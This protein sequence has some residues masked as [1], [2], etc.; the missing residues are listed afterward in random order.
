MP[1]A[2]IRKLLGHMKLE[3]TH[4]YA[5]STTVMIKEN[6]QKT[7]ARCKEHVRDMRLT[8]TMTL[9]V[10]EPSHVVSEPPASSPLV[11]VFLA[12]F[13]E[14]NALLNRPTSPWDT[15]AALA[16]DERLHNG[17]PVGQSRVGQ[18]R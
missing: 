17:Q 10:C 16:P 3:T 11:D 12:C 7:L 6:D 13:L 14:F 1:L 15:P 18:L 5:A 8:G 2:Q 9:P 4:V